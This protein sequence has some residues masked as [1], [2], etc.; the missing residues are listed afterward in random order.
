MEIR[1]T[2]LRTH[3]TQRAKH[4]ALFGYTSSVHIFEP[5]K[6]TKYC[7]AIT[8]I[9]QALIYS[10]K[11]PLHA[12]ACAVIR[13]D[14][15]ARNT[16]TLTHIQNSQHPHRMNFVDIFFALFSWISLN[17]GGLR[18]VSADVSEV[19][20]CWLQ[21]F[22]LWMQTCT[23][24]HCTHICPRANAWALSSCEQVEHSSHYSCTHRKVDLTSSST[25]CVLRCRDG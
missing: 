18:H 6:V 22:M 4:I 9:S 15:S 1:S 23:T 21:V 24:T 7:R 8:T 13:C 16:I 2:L 10:L 19:C 11:T 14:S 25:A 17:F 12:T 5:T 20:V 3:A